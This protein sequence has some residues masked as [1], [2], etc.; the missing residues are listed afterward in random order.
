[1]QVT[2]IRTL[3]TRYGSVVGLFNMDMVFLSGV[4]HVV[5]EWSGEPGDEAEPTIVVALDPRFLERLPAGAEITHQ[6]RVSVE[7]PRPSE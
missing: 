5:F 4:P 6:Y 3:V 7:D 1:M 2:K